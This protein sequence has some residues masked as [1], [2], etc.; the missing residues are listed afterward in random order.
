MPKRRY[1][2]PPL[3]EA[4]CEFRFASESSWD[5]AIPGLLAGRLS[6][7][8]PTRRQAPTLETTTRPVP[9]GI[10]QQLRPVQWLQLW[11]KDEKATVQVAPNLLSVNRLAPYP[12]WE[13]FL[14]LVKKSLDEYRTVA[15]PKG[16]EQ[17]TLRYINR[18]S[19]EGGIQLE[20]YFD[21]YPFVGRRLPQHL[22]SFIVGAQVPFEEERDT[23][24]MQMSS[25]LSGTPSIVLD[26]SYLL[27]QPGEVAAEGVFEWIEDAHERIEDTFEGCIKD[28]LRERF[29]EVEK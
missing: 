14:P 22:A 20:D 19:F 6:S 13:H 7:N 1:K 4:M 2:N 17:I 24:Q 25:S 16:F 23:L 29:G 15:D 18:I 11:Q 3:A 8:F 12:G 26:L 5:V 10:Q 28:P 21:F 9:D 27:N